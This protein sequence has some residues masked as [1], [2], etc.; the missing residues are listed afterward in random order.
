[1][2]FSVSGKIFWKDELFEKA[3]SPECIAVVAEINPICRT[4]SSVAIHFV[5]RLLALTEDKRQGVWP[6]LLCIAN[7]D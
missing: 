5:E 2:I 1:M 3:D 6:C 4:N 7:P